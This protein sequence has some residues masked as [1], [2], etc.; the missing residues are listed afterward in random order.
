MS[1]PI[2]V[3]CPAAFDYPRTTVPP[4]LQVINDGINSEIRSQPPFF[5]VVFLFFHRVFRPRTT[6]FRSIMV[7][8]AMISK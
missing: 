2:N 1:T 8:G 3:G 4:F 7:Y 5:I 6:C